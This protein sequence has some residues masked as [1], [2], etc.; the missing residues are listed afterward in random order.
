MS[1]LNDVRA[2]AMR[3]LATREHC[4]SELD[5]K[6]SQ[7]GFEPA[8]IVSIIDECRQNRFLSD[9][10]FTEAFV[11]SR[12]EKGNGPVRIRN[13]LQQHQI[14]AHL[15]ATYLDN[16][17]SVWT[18]CAA[19]VREKKFGGDIPEDYNERMK[20]ARFLEYRG[21]THDQIF[22]VLKEEEVIL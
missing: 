15:I 12:R 11:T 17:D 22:S 1:S 7:K 10:R 18:E 2:V 4:T 20:Q 3:L 6:L 8:D 14:D 21:F 5:R 9:E 19:R 13:E 16:R